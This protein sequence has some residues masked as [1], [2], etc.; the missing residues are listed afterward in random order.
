[1]KVIVIDTSLY[2]DLLLNPKLANRV[3][4]L[5]EKLVSNSYS[6]ILPQQVLDEIERNRLKGGWHVKKNTKKLE[7]SVSHIRDSQE[8]FEEN[9]T[10]EAALSL[11]ESRLEEIKNQKRFSLKK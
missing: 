11:M 4:P 1:M 3:I 7:D 10:I 6:L 9:E 8:A 2:R 5:L